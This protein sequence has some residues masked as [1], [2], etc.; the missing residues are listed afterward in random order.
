MS[1]TA[2][3]LFQH[4]LCRRRSTDAGLPPLPPP[5]AAAASLPFKA[6]LPVALPI[7]R[8]QIRTRAT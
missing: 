7:F 3:M 2:S 4:A 1:A 6:R 8:V 5:P